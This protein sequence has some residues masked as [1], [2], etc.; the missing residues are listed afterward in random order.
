MYYSLILT[1]EEKERF[2]IIMKRKLRQR[3]M[4]ERDLAE[5]LGLSCS[6]IYSLRSRKIGN[7]FVTAAIANYL[8]IKEGEWNEL[9]G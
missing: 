6:S 3:R 1:H 8:D 9:N 2:I 5:E 4:T 7:R